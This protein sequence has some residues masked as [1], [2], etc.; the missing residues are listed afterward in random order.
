MNRIQYAS[1]IACLV[2]STGALA[3]P[4]ADKV[5]QLGTTLTPWGAEIAGNKDSTIPAYTGGLKEPPAG[6]NPKSGKWV[7][8]YAA[9]KPLFSIDQKNMAQYADKLTPGAQEMLKRWPTY[10]I[11]IY[12]TR[13]GYPQM[14]KERAEATRKNATNPECKTTAD[15][16]GIVG[17]WGGT[18]F[19][20]PSNGNEVMWNSLLRERPVLAND[21]ATNYV[22]DSSGS[23]SAPQD[24]YGFGDSA[25][26]DGTE[27]PYTGGG[28]HYYRSLTITTSPARDAGGKIL[29]WYPLRYD[30]DDQRT[31]SY[32]TGQRRTRLA[33]EFAYDTPITALGGVLY[34]D[35]AAMFSGRMDRFNYKLVGK[36]E[37]YVPYNAV[38]A[39]WSP[40]EVAIGKQFVNPD[41]MRWELHRVWVVEATLKSGA[42]HAASKRNYY[43]DEDSWTIMASEGFDQSGKIFR[44]LLNHSSP[45]YSG[46]GGVADF[47]SAIQA[48]DLARGAYTVVSHHGKPNASYSTEPTRSAAFK[49]SMSPEAMAA[50]GVR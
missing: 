35:E 49:S 48:Y 13:R 18:P 31:W 5:K 38:K 24:Y 25:Y 9:D 12:P 30:T 32:T 1:A 47:Q 36:R 16:V 11:D 33:P 37:M 28:A 29:L 15:G 20:I 7:D 6:Y 10:R 41:V 8:P 22:I 23:Q 2:A 45:N 46:S 40:P 34:F 27:T 26:W 44:V 3:M 14:S 43:V 19:P 50:A 21:A 42:R 17:C 4:P 39:T